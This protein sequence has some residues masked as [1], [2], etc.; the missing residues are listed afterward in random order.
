MKAFYSIIILVLL[1]YS[2][3][4]KECM[5]H[6]AVLDNN[7]GGKI[8][9]SSVVDSISSSV[10][11]PSNFK[12]LRSDVENAVAAIQ[13]D[14]RVILYNPEFIMNVYNMTNSHWSYVSVIAHEIGH[15]LSGHTFVGKSLFQ[16]E[17][18]ADRFSGFVMRRLGAT[19][20]QATASLRLFD[21]SPSSHPPKN[22]R[23]NAVIVGWNSAGESND[24]K[25]CPMSNQNAKFNNVWVDHNVRF[26]MLVHI[27]LTVNNI[28]N[29]SADCV[30]Y[31]RKRNGGSLMD[32]DGDYRST[33]GSVSARV[34]I[35][36]TSPS[37]RFK[38]LQLFIPYQELHGA[39][40]EDLVFHAELF[41]GDKSLAKSWDMHF[42]LR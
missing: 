25:P 34:T 4:N 10:G 28:N 36:P 41:S 16:R 33:D 11:L 24:I 22:D 38:D 1:S 19:V 7:I 14:E 13:N 8:I 17:I 35:A 21:Q 9:N 32:T 23:I 39:A 20:D 37:E 40:N 18:E 6:D 30:I 26:G 5:Y 29:G 2:C 42:R 27:D 12:L 15:H 31:F 3:R